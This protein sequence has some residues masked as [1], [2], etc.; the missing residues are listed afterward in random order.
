MKAEISLLGTLAL[1]LAL[2]VQ[3][4]SIY[5]WEDENG[6]MH[7]SDTPQDGAVE[8]EMAP[9]QTFDSPVADQASSGGSNST[10]NDTGYSDIEIVSPADEET[11]W[12]TGGTVSVNYSI[13][14]RLK[15]GHQFRLYFN[16]QSLANP[17]SSTSYQITDV[18]R[19]THTLKVEVLNSSGEVMI[20]SAPVTFFYKQATADNRLI[21]VQPPQVENPIARPYRQAPSRVRRQA[22]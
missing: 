8:V 16:G 1:L 5:K 14:P 15:Q 10:D 4:Q 12:N 21:P 2:P 3:T 19:G 18:E 11:I 22:R 20:Q 7:Y 17:G 9:V 6:Q 13:S